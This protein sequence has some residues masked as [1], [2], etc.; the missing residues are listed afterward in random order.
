MTPIPVI[1][2]LVIVG[3]AVTSALGAEMGS[4]AFA[5]PK[6][7]T[8]TVPSDRSL[9]FAG[10]RSRWMI[11]CS[12]AASSASAICRA[13]GRA[14]SSGIGPCAMRSASVGP[15]TSSS[16]SAADAVRFFESVDAA[17]VRM[18]E[19]RER[20]G[21]AL[22]ARHRSGSCANVSGRILIATSRSSRVSRARYT[23]PM[24]PAPSADRISYGPSCAPAARVTGSS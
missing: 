21:F 18:I 12:W 9:I 6:S 20:L 5:R 8:F 2:G 24:P 3:D 1:A 17:D 14:S 13:I 15:S 10:L 11:P 19:R 7:S 16:T 22:K 4:S 23:S